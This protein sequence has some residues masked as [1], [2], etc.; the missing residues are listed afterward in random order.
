MLAKFSVKKPYFVVVGVVIVLILGVISLMSMKTDLLPEF[1]VPYLAV[2]TTDVGASPEQV[3]SEV[4]DV[5][6]GPLGTVS[7]VKSVES[8]SAE[9]YSVIFLE[10]EDG[11]DIDSAQVEASSKI[12]EVASELPDSAGTPSFMKMSTDSMA[13]VYLG[14]TSDTLS[15]AELSQKVK[16]DIIPELERQDGVASVTSAGLV[17]DTVEIQLNQDK[18]DNVNDGILGEVNDKFA[19]AKSK[20]SAA[21]RRLDSAEKKV[22]AQ[23]KKLRKAEKKAYAGYNKAKLA[24]NTLLSAKASANAQIAVIDA[25]ISQQQATLAQLEQQGLSSSTQA[26]SARSQLVTLSSSK[27]K[28]EN[29]IKNNIDTK[30]SKLAS[31]TSGESS[32]TLS[33][34]RAERKLDDALS[35][36]DESRDELAKSKSDLKKSRKK[37]TKNANIDKLVD[38]STLAKLIES[39]NLEMPAGYVDDSN[40]DQWVVKVGDEY[41]SV[42]ELKN[43]VL[44]KVDGVGDITL[45]DVADIVTT[46]NGDDSYARVNGNPA[47]ILPV[48]K[49]STASTSE[50]SDSVQKGIEELAQ[51]DPDV[52]VI[53]VMD[54]GTYID[55]TINT[56]LWSLIFGAILAFVVLAIF[57][58]NWRPT[59]IVA[60][61]I[62]FSVLFALV[63]MYF[64]GLT[65]NLMTLGA[66][67][68]AI[69]ML[70][71]NSIVVMENIYRMRA[72]GLSSKRAAAQGAVQV[73]G[74]VTASTI[75][76]ICVFLPFVF[77]NGTV[78]QLMIPFALTL[79]F[80]LLA[81]LIVALTVVPSIGSAVLDRGIV[82]DPRWFERLKDVYERALSWTLDHRA[83]VVVSA[84]VLLGVAI[85]L[86]ARMGIVMIPEM[87]S[88]QVMLIVEMDDGID[89]DEAYDAMD[90]AGTNIKKV[91]GVKEVGIVDETT[92]TSTISSTYEDMGTGIYDGYFYIY[93]TV[94]SSK[95]NTRGEMQDL[96]DKILDSVAN[97]PATFTPSNST[98]AMTSISGG[99]ATVTVSGTD[100]DK[101]LKL[102]DKVVDAMESVEGYEDVQNGQ[103]SAASTLHVHIDKDKVARMGTSVGQIYQQ[104]ASALKTETSAI[105]LVKK[106]HD[107][108]VKVVTEKLHKYTKDNI[109]DFEFE[110]G[111]G[112]KHRLSSVATVKKEEG[113]SQITRTDSTYTIDVT[114]SVKDGYN[115][116]LLARQ[117]QPKLDKIDVPDGYQIEI[118]GTNAEIEDMLKQMIGLLILGFIMVY[119]VMVA[120]FQ[121]LKS[122]FI[123]IFTVPL[124]F[125]GGLLFLAASGEQLSM[126]ALLGF[127]ILMGTV[128]NNGIVFVDY[129]NQLRLGGMDKRAALIATG[130][131]R[132]RP[133]LMT[134]L[135][136]IIS[137]C[138][139][140][141]SQQIGSEMERGMALVV[142]GGLL[143][144][145]FM[146]LFIVPVIY[147]AFNRKAL[148]AVDVDS[149]ID[150][151]A[152]DAA[153]YISIM[154]EGARETHYDESRA[155]YRSRR[156]A[157]RK[158]RNDERKARKAAGEKHATLTFG[159]RVR[160]SG[161]APETSEDTGAQGAD[162]PSDEKDSNN[163]E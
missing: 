76:S 84:L 7:G 27:Q 103:E 1:E 141:F 57:L 33:F 110:D 48:T 12:N 26:Q 69:G 138:P 22:K 79:S 92:A 36:I 38:A 60:F 124:A 59:I 151:D 45:G 139:L 23:K 9:N 21:E 50:V 77:A 16:D 146:T 62:P 87:T 49:S 148:K 96:Q 83:P 46:Q 72:R 126:M 114:A 102:S 73:T 19:T 88:D 29:S 54:Q 65:L 32:T 99:D 80:A 160:L 70:V 159:E 51:S 116:T 4:T 118:S 125:T 35:Q 81:S 63:L 66:L 157:E 5:L 2:V 11:T 154:G 120:Q 111:S 3:E 134:A 113:V 17:T 52:K 119:L 147:D 149:D 82:G 56:I 34:A 67:S 89:Q 98:A 91:E 140:I 145:T 86:V 123:I 144:A 71:D 24:T 117:L 55:T 18:I 78:R 108:E 150:L 104:L 156:K 106:N 30:L 20:I 6:E 95:V 31:A 162:E 42:D 163:Q 136:T 143:Y 112:K 74:A 61:S 39:Q 15:S 129:A 135:T 109:L 53:A 14:V 97:L 43:M 93:A 94:D 28:I 131:V 58:R 122:P 105:T 130:R 90:T 132:M 37:A 40:G 115:V 121:N 85:A 10:F 133:I 137:V 107:V 152:D 155:D 13:S 75:T 127:V 47:V 41:T 44:T 142:A 101:V 128:V 100:S 8:T 153:A 158:A 68:L 161:A 64:C 25:Q